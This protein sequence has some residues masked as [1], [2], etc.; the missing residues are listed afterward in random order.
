MSELRVETYRMPA[1]HLGAEN[2]LPPLDGCMPYRLQDDYDRT[3]KEREFKAV[4]LENE[5]L[6]ATFLTELG[7]RLWSLFY[8][9][10]NRELLYVNP[11]FQPGNLAIR[12]AWFSGGVEWNIAVRGHT[13]Y[14]CSPL[15]AARV[16]GDDGLPI[17]RM[18]EWDRV[19]MTPYQIDAFLP[20]DSMFLFVR[21]RIINP[22]E[23]EVPMYWWSNTAV[24]EKPEVRVLA[25][26]EQAYKYGYQGKMIQ[27]PIPI[28]D[29][30]DLSYPTNSNKSADFFYCIDANQQPWVTA[31]DE[32]GRGLIQTST[33]RLKGRKMFVWGMGPG[34]RHWQEFLSV[35]NAPYIEIQAGLARTQSEYLPM[36]A[37]AE[38]TW[39]E[40][41]GLMEADPEIVHKPDW[42]TAY[43]SV[44]R[45]LK[46]MMP[47]ELLESELLNSNDMADKPPDE[48]IQRGSGWG[49]LEC[50]RRERSGEKPFGPPSMVFDD[51]SF[52][53]DQEF[54]LTLLEDGELPYAEPTALP[55][56]WMVQSEWQK[57]LQDSVHSGR[58][59]HWLAW[60]HLGVIYYSEKNIDAAR[61]AWEKSLALE[62]SPWAYRNMAV[63]AKHEGRLAEAADLLLAACQM[64]P[65]APSLALECCQALLD[66]ERPQDMLNF[67]SDLPRHI[68][69]RGR[70]RVMEARAALKMGHL[71]TVK[72]ILQSRPLVPDIREGEVT[73][74][75]LWF[76]MHEK[77]LAAA[78]NVS[79]D[80]KL[81]Q[82]V[83][84]DYPPPSWLDFRQT[85]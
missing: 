66:T 81:R 15:F 69:D 53:A 80:D 47:Q 55:S 68:R 56:A 7:G 73:L 11:V 78:E 70:M 52:S 39:L 37:G 38:W 76:E 19:R 17:L 58:S 67:L 62:P 6:R 3:K 48:I 21:I 30:V 64:A 22:N 40:A 26:A 63:L 1:A 14:T 44:D 33:A 12:N 85:T 51:D 45:K 18:Y 46:E 16:Q 72:E 35:P 65:Q 28:S 82:R 42:R 49:A 50:R 34:G 13:A 36:T 4:V 29:G 25:P 9:P 10:S 71:Q 79:I 41:Y 27:V 77:R 43:Q 74:S 60:L 2:P 61:R 54:W 59:N 5:V 75:N 8:K 23:H 83:R 32:Q 31:L 24:P 84:R 20:D 57:L